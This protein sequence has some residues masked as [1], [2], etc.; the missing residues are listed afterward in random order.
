MTT[1]ENE[2]TE[3]LQPE[4]DSGRL[5]KIESE[6]ALFDRLGRVYPI[7]GTKI[8]WVKVPGAILGECSVY[9]SRGIDGVQTREFIAFYDKIVSRYDIAGKGIYMGD[10]LIDFAVA[11]HLHAIRKVLPDLFD[12][13]HHHYLVGENFEWC[14][15]WTMEGNMAF[16]YALGDNK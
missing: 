10:G 8:H 5:H 13:P 11:G 7:Y 3:R 9:P 6:A 15:S 1:I 14:F 4:F 16:G 12:V 2:L